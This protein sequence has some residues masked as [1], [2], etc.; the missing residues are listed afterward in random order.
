MHCMIDWST[1]ATGA[2]GIAGIGGSIWSAR[3]S[4]KSATSDLRP[5][6]GAENERVRMSEKRRIYAVYL[7][8]TTRYSLAS[9]AAQVARD[10]GQK[11]LSDSQY[12][13]HTTYDRVGCA[14]EFAR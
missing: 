14:G 12:S 13:E 5:T 7:S 8:S 10:A 6:I 9:G 3:I 4:R 2:V 11:L 1:I